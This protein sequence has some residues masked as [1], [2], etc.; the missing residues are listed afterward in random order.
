MS[1]LYVGFVVSVI[2]E[3]LQ[4]DCGPLSCLTGG[5]SRIVFVK[6][7]D[8]TLKTLLRNPLAGGESLTTH[9][10]SKQSMSALDQQLNVRSHCC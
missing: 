5:S 4:G 6:G 10:N 2:V 3:D 9:P 7:A 8:S 1:L